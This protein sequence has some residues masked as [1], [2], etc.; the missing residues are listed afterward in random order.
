[1]SSIL[2]VNTKVHIQ[3]TPNTLTCNEIRKKESQKILKFLIET[4]NLIT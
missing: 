4:Q 1:M 2:K 3:L